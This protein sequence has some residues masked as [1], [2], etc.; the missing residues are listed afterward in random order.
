MYIK[1]FTADISTLNFGPEKDT[2]VVH[3]RL[4]ANGIITIS[5][6]C[7]LTKKHIEA[8]GLD[9]AHIEL[10]LKKNGLSF[11]MSDTDVFQHQRIALGQTQTNNDKPST[12]ESKDMSTT[13]ESK[14]FVRKFI[15]S[16]YTLD[17]DWSER[18]FELAKSLFIADHSIF[19]TKEQKMQRAFL[20][21][22]TFVVQYLS[23]AAK[24]MGCAIESKD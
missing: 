14:A 10:H 7:H 6:L 12:K 24:I 11:G 3:D 15:T 5:E 9:S 16:L 21:A 22:N 20:L 1:D 4:H 13:D 18:Y 8:L 19:R 17:A 2:K 23:W